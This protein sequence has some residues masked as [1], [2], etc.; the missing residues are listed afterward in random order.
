MSQLIGINWHFNPPHNIVK[1][2]KL[3]FIPDKD[4]FL[5]NNCLITDQVHNFDI[6]ITFS[7]CREAGNS[8][9]LA[10]MWNFLMKYT[11]GNDIPEIRMKKLALFGSV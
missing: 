8:S 4:Y 9:C 3:I 10:K 7:D 11:Y 1:R 5:L 6:K 2:E